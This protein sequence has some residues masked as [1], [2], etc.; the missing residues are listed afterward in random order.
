MANQNKKDQKAKPKNQKPSGVKKNAPP[1]KILHIHNHNHQKSKVKTRNMVT[2]VPLNGLR[3]GFP[4][5]LLPTSTQTERLNDFEILKIESINFSAEDETTSNHETLASTFKLLM[6]KMNIIYGKIDRFLHK[7]D[8]MSR[9]ALSAELGDN[10]SSEKDFRENISL[11]L[12]G[13]TTFEYMVW[14]GYHEFK[15]NVCEIMKSK[16]TLNFLKNYFIPGS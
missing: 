13:Y 2:Q 10:F 4:K 11:G 7:K 9:R 8:E 15:M 1:T 12:M 6:H 14:Q 3:C 5:Q 16:Y